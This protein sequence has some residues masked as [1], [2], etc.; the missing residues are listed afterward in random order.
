VV[1]ES[2]DSSIIGGPGGVLGYKRLII[3]MAGAQLSLHTFLTLT[4]SFLV[5]HL[6]FA[7]NTGDKKVSPVYV[8]DRVVT[9]TKHACIEST[10]LLPKSINTTVMPASPHYSVGCAS[11]VLPTH[12]ELDGVRIAYFRLTAVH[13]TIRISSRMCLS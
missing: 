12:P 10:R 13:Q 8:H 6:Q 3:S 2:Q 1:G 5:Y 11:T 9:A 7:T 4:S